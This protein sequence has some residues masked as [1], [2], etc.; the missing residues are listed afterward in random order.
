MELNSMIAERNARRPQPAPGRQ[1]FTMVEL[2]MVIVIIAIL[3]GLLVPAVQRGVVSAREAA[4]TSEIRQLETA[5]ASFKATYGVEPPST[6]TLYERASQIPTASQSSLRRIWPHFAFTGGANGYGNEYDLDGDGTS[7]EDGVSVTL[8]GANCLVFFL[9]GIQA[10]TS[11]Q[12]TVV[13]FSKSPTN[14]FAAMAAT[15]S[16]EGPFFEF[17]VDRL[18][19]SPANAAHPNIQRFLVYFDPLPSQEA[20]YVYA[21]SN[22]GRGYSPTVAADLWTGSADDL[23]DI[24][25]SGTAAT[26]PAI[27][28]KGFQI[29]SPGYDHEYGVGGNFNAT[30][31]NSGIQA[32]SPVVGTANSDYDNLTN[33]NAGRLKP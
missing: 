16:R 15:E 1:G 3:I 24:Y 4:V 21:S 27:K 32:E 12:L 28:P 23:N 8:H 11:P 22:D 19:L 6:I 20:P 26:S 5:I 14:P 31:T 17:K 13:G 9:G 29:I 10:G 2:L 7:G 33:F 25:R 18:H 30:A